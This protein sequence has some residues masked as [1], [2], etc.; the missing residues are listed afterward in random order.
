MF[1]ARGEKNLEGIYQMPS[2]TETLPPTQVFRI[3][4]PVRSRR[5]ARV[6]GC[7][8]M[9]DIQIPDLPFIKFYV[10]DYYR[11]TAGLSQT[12]KAAWMAFVIDYWNHGNS[13]PD[14]DSILADIAGCKNQTEWKNMKPVLIDKARFKVI[15]QEWRHPY[16]ILARKEAVQ[17][18][19]SNK[20]KSEKARAAKRKKAEE[21][22]Q[23]LKVVEY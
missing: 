17:T 19:L 21:A 20:A 2:Y 23:S 11:F 16:Y 3:R 15:N 22:A 4:R 6:K 14:D 9:A 5:R 18:Y 12:E 10:G 1:V 13:P 8:V 7:A